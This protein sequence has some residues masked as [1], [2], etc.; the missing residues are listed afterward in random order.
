MVS[1]DHPDE[2]PSCDGTEFEW[3]DGT[4]VCQDCGKQVSDYAFD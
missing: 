3:D 2:C 1:K 4:S